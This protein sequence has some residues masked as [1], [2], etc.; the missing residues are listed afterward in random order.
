[1]MINEWRNGMKEEKECAKRE[2]NNFLCFL[3][4]IKCGHRGK[5]ERIC[6]QEIESCFL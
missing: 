3:A 5:L 4:K 2:G 6:F 1:M